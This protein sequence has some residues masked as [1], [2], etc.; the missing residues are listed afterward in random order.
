MEGDTVEG[1]QLHYGDFIVIAGYFAFVLFI[2]LW[3]SRQ[4]RGSAGGYFLAGRN[5]HWIP[6]GASLFASN[7][8]SIHFVGLAGSGAASGIAIGLYELNALYIL[9]LLGYIFLPVYIASG[10]YTMPEYLKCRFGGQRIQIYMA[11]LAL[12]VYIFTKISADL[13]AGA[14]FIEQSMHWNLYLS[15]LLLLS[16][17]TI[18][19]I[20]GGLTAVIWTDFIQTII[21]I[22]G[23]L[24]LMGLSF[25]KVGGLNGIVEK[26]PHAIANTTKYSNTT[27]GV[28]R[29]DYMHLFRDPVTGDLP[30]PG[31]VG[32]SI[33]SI[34]YWCSDQVIVQR[35]L[36]GKTFDHAKAGTVL[37][38]FIKILPLFLLVFPGMV[39]RILF[40]DTVG[41]ADPEVCMSVC[42]SETGC[43]N[44]AYPT[45]VINLMPAGA[46]GMML[47]VM[48]A[49]LMSSLTSIFNSSST[50]FAMDIW[51]RIRKQASELEIMIVGRL[52]VLVLVV[53][54][55]VWIP[56]IRASQG[57]ELFVYIQEVSSFMQP[58]ICCIFLL[59][60]FWERLNEAGAFYGLVIGMVIGLVR[61][62][63]EYSYS[64]PNCVDNLPDP[65]PSIIK[66]FHYLYFSSFLFVVTGLVAIGVSL[67]TKPIDKRC[68]RR[69]TWWTR[70]NEDPRLD[71][72]EWLAGQSKDSD[73][74]NSSVAASTEK[75]KGVEME[76]LTLKNG[77]AEEAGLSEKLANK[78]GECNQG[79]S[80]MKTVTLSTDP[81]IQVEEGP[82]RVALP[83]RV[84]Y[85]C[86]GIEEDN[87]TEL[88]S[89][90]VQRNEIQ[91]I[92]EHPVW[93]KVSNVFAILAMI[94]AVFLF[95]FFA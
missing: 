15:I 5:M 29:E 7:I 93:S 48:M 88:A 37:C 95:A 32:M 53:I 55:I 89:H 58:P 79:D 65:R 49:A 41:C 76:N 43:S 17:A 21:M 74:D 66:D 80:L 61:F 31:I 11:V 14:L 10:V 39:S 90:T 8:G 35:A 87:K 57:S 9:M 77:K 4:N 51:T 22:I 64:M 13:Y 59:G 81:E 25:A 67:L 19:T 69:L 84:I 16:I 1:T 45:L 28:P 92:K 23:A 52:F 3:T 46:R 26:Y 56:V 36:A 91:S 68:L 24:V 83:R 78:D 38:A 62:I 42:G 33:N 47:A 12:L 27:C 73:D 75:E 20:T 63:V 2:G 18:F 82:V 44:I 72:D 34:W 71:I 30:W 60:L 86:C 54:S 6:V 50:I 94:A 40:P 85:W 70:H